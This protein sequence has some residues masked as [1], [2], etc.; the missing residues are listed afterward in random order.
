VFDGYVLVSPT[1]ISL[2]PKTSATNI[3]RSCKHA[4]SYAWRS[5]SM[6]RPLTV[7]ATETKIVILRQ[8]MVNPPTSNIMKLPRTDSRAVISGQK[9]R[10]QLTCFTAFR[11]WGVPPP[12]EHDEVLCISSMVDVLRLQQARQHVSTLH[13]NATRCSSL[14]VGRFTRFSGQAVSQHSTALTHGAVRTF[15]KH[16]RTARLTKTYCGLGWAFHMGG[17]ETRSLLPHPAQL[18]LHATLLHWQL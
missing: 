2:F 12:K 8:I 17:R 7:P 5:V 10:S 13:K 18:S 9:R 6:S 4:A 3:F 11:C 15:H 1:R 16:K 14:H